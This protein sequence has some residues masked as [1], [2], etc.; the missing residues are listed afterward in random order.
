MV[1]V[2]FSVIS[3]SSECMIALSAST[4]LSI[5]CIKCS[6]SVSKVFLKIFEIPLANL[7]NPEKSHK[8]LLY[9][10]NYECI[11]L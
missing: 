7:G 10:C 5:S 9:C 1:D 2:F 4:V 3:L 8:I 6:L 11:D